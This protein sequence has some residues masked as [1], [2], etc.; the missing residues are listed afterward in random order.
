MQPCWRQKVRAV[1]LA[2]TT[3][4]AGQ[5]ERTCASLEDVHT[6]RMPPL[7]QVFVRYP[8]ER[9]HRRS[10]KTDERSSG[11]E[12]LPLVGLTIGGLVLPLLYAFS[13]YLHFADFPVSGTTRRNTTE[14]GAVQQ[15]GSPYCQDPSKSRGIRGGDSVRSQ[16]RTGA[17]K[18]SDG[19]LPSGGRDP[20]LRHVVTVRATARP[21]RTHTPRALRLAPSV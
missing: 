12:R 9:Q 3:Q 20:W 1:P 17:I 21:S 6:F 4:Q 19:R 11:A 2:A 10:P 18:S 7:A 13:A 5:V 8:Y 14:L 16:V 15:I